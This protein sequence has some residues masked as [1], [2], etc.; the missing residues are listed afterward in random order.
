MDRTFTYR[1]LLVDDDSSLLFTVATKLRLAGYEVFSAGDGSE[2]LRFIDRHGLPH[3]AI[4]DIKMPV[5]DGLTFCRQVQRYSDL[6]VILLTAVDE[7]D[8][9]VDAIRH[10]AEDYLTKPFSLRELEVRVERVLRRVGDF[11]YALGPTIA[12]DESLSLDFA[13]QKVSLH[14]ASIPLTDTEAKLLYL[15]VRNAG[16]P[17]TRDFL[18]RRLW[19]FDEIY[20]DS[21]RV[22]IF[23]L[24]QKIEADPHRPVYILTER[25]VGYRFKAPG[26]RYYEEQ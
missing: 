3:L 16:Q 18:L 22:H 11:A 6:P 15:L 23:N 26:N 21:L 10:Y 24:R 9:I 25:G 8:V 12:V 1:I 7:E 13:H 19:P 14:Q 17:V 2:A 5:M 20:E 4:V